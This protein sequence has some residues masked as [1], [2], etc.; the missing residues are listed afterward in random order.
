MASRVRERPLE[1][2]REPVLLALV[3]L[4]A[5][6]VTRIAFAA[7]FPYFL[8]EGTYAV[9]SWEGSRSLGGL[10]S[11][12]SIGREPLMFWLGIPWVKLGFNPLDA[13]RI[14]SICCGIVTTVFT[15]LTAREL[16][17]RIAG[18]AAAG[19]CVVMPF[20]VVHDGIGIIEPLVTAVVAAALFL[21]IRMA[22]RPGLGVATALGAV[23]AAGMLTKENTRI[24]LLLLP[25]SLICFDWARAGRE[26]RLKRWLG[27]VGVC[28]LFLVAAQLV[29]R[30]S[31][32][33]GEYQDARESPLLYTVRPLRDVLSDPFEFG[34]TWAA[35]H[36]AFTGYITIPLLLAALA[37]AILAIAR[38][39][40][41][42]VLVLV[43]VLV[44]FSISMLFS[45]APFPRHVMYLIPPVVVL[46]AYALREAW[47]ALSERLPG[48]R[49]VAL[50][51][52]LLLLLLAPALRF[53][54]RVLANPDT[55]RYPGLD[56][57]QYVTGTG[58]GTVW[59]PIAREMERRA[60]GPEVVVISP[61]AYTQV[62]EMLLGPNPRYRF[63]PGH[64][65]L[66]RRAQF[67]VDDEIPFLDGDAAA[68][69][70]ELHFESVAEFARPRG[71]KVARLMVRPAG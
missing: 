3:L 42:G 44:P 61:R 62:L 64:S 22:R 15:A 32:R 24:T 4:G 28:A 33:Y 14:V 36:P 56:D 17:G 25:V 8:D 65:P 69:M 63:V 59:P 34:A 58:G 54:L 50:A 47:A 46:I 53:D 5:Y 26:D 66:A 30:A 57:V 60:R 67:V 49:G 71:G 31:S 39:S 11:S 29:L 1:T 7:R 43:W 35:Y 41:P 68:I 37:G 52:V 48:P 70:R 23:L 13:V 51:A 55:A 45:T 27:G 38:R 2:L 9:F 16:G 12:Y 21:Q 10:Y 20:L 18:W 19:L 40:A 6:L